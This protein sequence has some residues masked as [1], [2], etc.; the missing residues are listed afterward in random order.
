MPA[1]APRAFHFRRLAAR[2]RYAVS[3]DGV[4]SVPRRYGVV[5]TPP[6]D[7]CNV[8]FVAVYA[9]ANTPDVSLPVFYAEVGTDIERDVARVLR[10]HLLLR[11]SDYH[12]W[13]RS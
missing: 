10:V 9:N 12:R 3:F 8:T 5:Q 13:A 4:Q 2:R 6:A 7:A 1:N 11:C